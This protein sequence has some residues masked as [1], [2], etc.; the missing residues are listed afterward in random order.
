MTKRTAYNVE[1]QILAISTKLNEYLLW[2]QSIETLDEK[3]RLYR[4]IAQYLRQA[5]DKMKLLESVARKEL[6]ESKFAGRLIDD[7]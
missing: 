1:R 6:V 4:D 2:N 3:V 5:A 7:I